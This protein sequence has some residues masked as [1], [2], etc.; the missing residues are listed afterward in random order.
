MSISITYN[1]QPLTYIHSYA[2]AVCLPVS[3]HGVVGAV[4]FTC[5]L[6][7][8]GSQPI[9]T[10]GLMFLLAQKTVG[11]RTS[12]PA[13]LFSIRTRLSSSFRV[14]G[15]KTTQCCSPTCV[16]T[17]LCAHNQIPM[18]PPFTNAFPKTSEPVIIPSPVV[19]F[20]SHHI[21]IHETQFVLTQPQAYVSC[22]DHDG[23]CSRTSKDKAN[24]L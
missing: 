2:A 7:R 3:P 8:P 17:Y 12:S 11:I 18:S 20:V 13:S 24:E 5:F 4:H 1:I 19:A 9:V 6:L 16:F 22:R 23:N 14:Q 10:W 21:A 15:L